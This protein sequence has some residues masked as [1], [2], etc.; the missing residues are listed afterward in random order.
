MKIDNIDN[1]KK[2]WFIGDFIPSLYKTS[3]FEVAVKHYNKGEK[4]QKHIHKVA[5]EF[6][7]IISGSVKMN[8]IE[9]K[10]GDIVVL[11]PNE[12]SDFESLSDNTK[13][14]VVKIPSVK[15]DKYFV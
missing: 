8:N 15:D 3:N 14:L 9:Y 12:A 1:F 13:T 11:E 4:E 6:T 5:T 10:E 2:G 7:I